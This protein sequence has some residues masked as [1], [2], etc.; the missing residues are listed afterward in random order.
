MRRIVRMGFG[1]LALPA[2]ATAVAAADLPG[3]HDLP[4]LT[5]FDGA[6]IVGYSQLDHDGLVLP[7]GPY[8]AAKPERF[9]HTS[10]AQ[11][12]VTR[13]AYVAPKG[14]SLAEV[15]ENYRSA[16]QAAGFKTGFQCSNDACGGFDFSTAIVEP[17]L[18]QLKGERNTMVD[19]LEAVDN[20]LRSLTARLQRPAGDV[21]LSL[22]VVGNEGRPVGVLVRA[23]EAGAMQTGQVQVDAKAIGKGLDQDGHIALYGI[24][25]ATDSATLAKSSDGTLAE[26]AALMKSRPALKVYIVGHTD[27]SGSLAHN[28]TLSKQRAQAVAEALASHYGVARARM[29]TSG[30]ASYAPVAS[31]RDAAG[32]ARNR[33]VELVEQ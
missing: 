20:Q 13:I 30:L 19:T 2:F 3:S 7:M 4:F 6:S 11:G 10:Q 33:R 17:E 31:N 16:L 24:T 28:T 1:L 25:F 22:L 14:K 12:R 26:M 5:R 21:D 32:R 23:V 27:N 18:S 8:A 9:A 29:A 15:F